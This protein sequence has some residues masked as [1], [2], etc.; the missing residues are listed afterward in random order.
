[1]SDKISKEDIKETVEEIEEFLR[2]FSKGAKPK[3]TDKGNVPGGVFRRANQ[4]NP[5]ITSG[6]GS[7]PVVEQEVEQT[8]KKKE[9][10]DRWKKHLDNISE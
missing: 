8:D 3:R 2:N 6:S 1:M 10:S 4:S 7:R 9:F 5:D